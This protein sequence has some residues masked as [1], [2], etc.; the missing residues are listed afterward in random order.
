MG[1]QDY[2][3]NNTKYILL[4]MSEFQFH[5]YINIS[6][7][8][9]PLTNYCSVNPFLKFAMYIKK[10]SWFPL[11]FTFKFCLFIQKFNTQ[12]TILNMT[13]K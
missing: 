11:Y 2:N 12:V 13:L 4:Y 9:F 7:L 6:I 10:S 8:L 1:L 3:I 5:V